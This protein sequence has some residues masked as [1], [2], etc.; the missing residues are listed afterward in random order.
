MFADG[1]S[2]AAERLRPGDKVAL[3][4]L[5]GLAWDEDDTD[6]EWG[7]LLGQ[8]VGDGG[9]NP[10]NSGGTYVRFYGP[11]WDHP[12]YLRAVRLV[13]SLGARADFD[14]GDFHSR[15]EPVTIRTRALED[16]TN[17]YILPRSKDFRPSFFAQSYSFKKGFLQGMF[18]TDGTVFGSNAKGRAIRLNQSNLGRME[19][20]QL[21]LL[22]CGLISKLYH[23]E[24]EG[25][26]MMPDGKGGQ[27]EYQTKENFDLHMSRDNLNLFERGIGFSNEDKKG[28]LTRLIQSA[29]R[30]PYQSRFEAE[31]LTVE[32]TDGLASIGPDTTN[33]RFV[34]VNGLLARV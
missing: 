19:R 8:I 15:S 10:N 26:R 17:R 3:A 14:G 6:F 13:H 18:D 21:L 16:F 12:S 27:K 4:N 28:R 30:R 24:D 29:K 34:F 11:D 23:R 5:R 33:G 9:H 20:I 1:S 31:V 2:K 7:W 32:Q 22:S 25:P